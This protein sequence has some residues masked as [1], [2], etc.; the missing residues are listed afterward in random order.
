MWNNTIRKYTL[1][2]VLFGLAFPV[3]AL[4]FEGIRLGMSFSFTSIPTLHR[5]N[6]LLYMVDSA[7]LFLGIFAGLG[8]ISKSKADELNIQLNAQLSNLETTK[9][10]CEALALK[11]ELQYDRIHK[12]AVD[13]SNN[14][15][16]TEVALTSLMELSSTVKDLSDSISGHVEEIADTVKTSSN[17]TN[18]LIT[19]VDSACHH[20]ASS[21]DSVEDRF[22]LLSSIESEINK[23]LTHFH[24]LDSNVGSIKDLISII[25]TIADDIDLL[26]LNA[27]IEAARAGESGRGFEIVAKEVGRLAKFT[28]ETVNTSSQTIGTLLDSTNQLS[29][30]FD[31]IMIN[32]SNL[33]KV[34]D[35]LRDVTDT[36]SST[37]S[38]MKDLTA[39]ASRIIENQS[40]S[41]QSS[42][43]SIDEKIYSLNKIEEISTSIS[44]SLV[45]FS[46][47]IKALE[48]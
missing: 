32:L 10:Q 23:D 19:E 41:M 35:T 28:K 18:S 13:L 36:I 43:E 16:H 24:D 21:L 12:T 14:Y 38:S 11:S 46:S 48:D 1:I 22:A 7:P 37:K 8:G 15:H 31:N 45:Q 26:A 30:D 9:K 44:K 47:D 25:T 40:S 42:K 39:K 29:S 20:I 6:P 27:S 33:S 34:R 3:G 4:V 2:G 17:Y 5:L